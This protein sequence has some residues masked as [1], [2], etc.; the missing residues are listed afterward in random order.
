MSYNMRDLRP[1]APV[2]CLCFA[3]LL[4]CLPLSFTHYQP[5]ADDTLEGEEKIEYSRSSPFSA[6]IREEAYTWDTEN[7]GVTT[8]EPS[9]Q[10]EEKEELGQLQN[11]QEPS[12][13]RILRRRDGPYIWDIEKK[14]YVPRPALKEQGVCSAKNYSYSS[15]LYPFSA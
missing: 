14:K 1:F 7:G 11:I 3:F 5:R 6:P 15:K 9:K 4:L 12:S 10:L 2:R 8:D 13:S